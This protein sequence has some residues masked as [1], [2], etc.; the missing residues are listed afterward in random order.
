MTGLLKY[1]A[2]AAMALSMA[3]ASFAVPGYPGRPVEWR[4]PGCDGG[5]DFTGD[6]GGVASVERRNGH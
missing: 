2:C 1:I 3:G 4:L 5:E 6:G